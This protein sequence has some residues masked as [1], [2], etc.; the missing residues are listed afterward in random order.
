MTQHCFQGTQHVTLPCRAGNAE[1]KASSLISICKKTSVARET[2][3]KFPI[4]F[5]SHLYVTPPHPPAWVKHNEQRK[6]QVFYQ[7]VP[8]HEFSG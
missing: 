7:N 2:K 4:K 1:T 5:T 8:D 3:A 6:L